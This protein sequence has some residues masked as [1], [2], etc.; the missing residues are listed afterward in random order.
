MAIDKRYSFPT[1]SSAKIL[2][3]GLL[4]G[5]YVGLVPAIDDANPVVAGATIT[6]TQSA[7]VLG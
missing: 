4:G 1:D 5:Q 2:T 7:L 6:Q 3:S